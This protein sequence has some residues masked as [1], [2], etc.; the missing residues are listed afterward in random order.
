MYNT[1]SCRMN[2]EK[3]R[4]RRTYIINIFYYCHRR[5]RGKCPAIGF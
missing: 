1:Y 5:R 2:G 4:V 3:W